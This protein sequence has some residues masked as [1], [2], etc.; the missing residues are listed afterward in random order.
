MKST[1]PLILTLVLMVFGVVC[2]FADTGGF[3]RT[4]QVSGQVDLEVT[5]ASGNV[6][7]HAGAAGSVH[8]KATIKSQN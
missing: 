8:V 1:K 6:T 7:V 5:S 3:E 2:A 4:L